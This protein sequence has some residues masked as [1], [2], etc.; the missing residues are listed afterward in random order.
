MLAWSLQGHCDLLNFFPPHFPND[1]AVSLRNT[2]FVSF[3]I[4][5]NDSYSPYVY[6]RCIFHPLSRTCL[7]TLLLLTT[8]HC[9]K[10]QSVICCFG[11]PSWRSA[12]AHAESKTGGVQLLG[13]ILHRV[14]RVCRALLLVHVSGLSGMCWPCWGDAAS[15]VWSMLELLLSDLPA[16]V[17]L[18][19]RCS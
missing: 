9:A 19:G 13:H 10:Q 16:S 12:L 7:T 4:C 11:H 1:M 8:D 5:H 3:Y 6:R 14:H 17:G 15:Q 2:V 18:S